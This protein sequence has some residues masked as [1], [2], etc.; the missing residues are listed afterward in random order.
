VQ[1]FQ[2][3]LLDLKKVKLDFKLLA[4]VVK[5]L[6]WY[7]IVFVNSSQS[8]LKITINLKRLWAPVWHARSSKQLKFLKYFF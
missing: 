1:Q 6:E 4:S 8:T 2:R 3:S 5:K 7:K